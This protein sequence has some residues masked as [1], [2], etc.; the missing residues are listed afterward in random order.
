[1]KVPL[2]QITLFVQFDYFDHADFDECIIVFLKKKT[3]SEHVTIKKKIKEEEGEG[4]YFRHFGGFQ[5]V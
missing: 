2:L 4:L 3:K 5:L 1:L